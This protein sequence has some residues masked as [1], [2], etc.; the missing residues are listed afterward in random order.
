PAL[1]YANRAYGSPVTLGPITAIRRQVPSRAGESAV[2]GC[3]STLAPYAVPRLLAEFLEH[4]P[5]VD[6][7]VV[8]GDQEQLVHRLRH[9]EIEFALTYDDGL[10]PDAHRTYLADVVPYVLL[11]ALHP[12][13]GQAAVSLAA[14]VDEPMV[15]L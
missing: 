11:P 12:L 4:H 1:V 8:E 10:P 5:D 6:V 14:L 7:R 2:F 15:L 9:G 3:F 13:A